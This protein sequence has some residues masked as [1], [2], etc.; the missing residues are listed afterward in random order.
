MQLML[1]THFLAI[2]SS[3]NTLSSRLVE[4]ASNVNRFIDYTQNGHIC[5]FLNFQIGQ[6]SLVVAVE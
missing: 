5:M 2:P 3:F 1:V 6:L 4:S